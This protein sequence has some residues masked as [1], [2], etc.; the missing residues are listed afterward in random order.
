MVADPLV[1][2]ADQR[3][4]DCR[5]EPAVGLMLEQALDELTVELVEP[6]VD[7]VQRGS[8][9]GLSFDVRVDGQPEEPGRLLAHLS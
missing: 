3:Q 7:V 2:P 4:L 1:V 9:S 8:E 5:L 6:V